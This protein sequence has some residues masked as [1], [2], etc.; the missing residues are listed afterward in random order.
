VAVLDGDAKYP[1]VRPQSAI[2]PQHD[3][4]IWRTE[5]SRVGEP[6]WTRKY[7]WATMFPRP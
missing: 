3:T 5:C 2:V 1:R 6:S 4:I 7:F